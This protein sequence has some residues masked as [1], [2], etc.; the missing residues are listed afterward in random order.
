MADS[1]CLEHTDKEEPRAIGFLD[2]FLYAS[3][4]TFVVLHLGLLN[5]KIFTW[6]K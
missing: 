1:Q 2:F 6:E 5:R 3:T 4:D